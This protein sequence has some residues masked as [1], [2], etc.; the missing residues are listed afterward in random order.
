M[1]SEH[2][3]ARTA[4]STTSSLVQVPLRRVVVRACFFKFGRFWTQAASGPVPG[5]HLLPLSGDQSGAL[6]VRGIMITRPQSRLGSPS[7]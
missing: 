3:R 4:R 6:A 2:L 5:M 1:N 7:A